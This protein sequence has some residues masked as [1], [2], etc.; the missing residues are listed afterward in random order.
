MTKNN[1]ELKPSLSTQ[2]KISN[3]FEI[4]RQLDSKNNGFYLV[5]QKGSGLLYTMKCLSN[6]CYYSFS[7]KREILTD[8]IDKEI[9]FTVFTFG[10]S[11]LSSLY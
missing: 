9:K 7:D 3:E 6:S 2:K 1:G 8:P 11:Y 10:H 5:K 4:L